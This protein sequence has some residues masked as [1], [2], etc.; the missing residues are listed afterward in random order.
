LTSVPCRVCRLSRAWPRPRARHWGFAQDP[1]TSSS[2]QIAL[3]RTWLF[4]ARRTFACCCRAG[5]G[6][7]HASRRFRPQSTLLGLLSSPHSALS[8]LY[9]LLRTISIIPTRDEPLSVCLCSR[10]VLPWTRTGLSCRPQPGSTPPTR[11][12]PARGTCYL[13]SRQ[14]SSCPL[15][16]HPRNPHNV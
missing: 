8:V 1:R 2:D 16:C 14:Q 7:I 13:Y 6:Q 5:N 11:G 15:C 4:A 9:A 3:C 12:T 10:S